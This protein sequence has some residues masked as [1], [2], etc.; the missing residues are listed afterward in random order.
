M[1]EVGGSLEAAILQ[2]N[3]LPHLSQLPHVQSPCGHHH[4]CSLLPTMSGLGT[5]QGWRDAPI[6]FLYLSGWL[7]WPCLSQVGHL[8]FSRP[9]SEWAW[10][11]PAGL[12]ATPAFPC[13]GYFP[14]IH[15]LSKLSSSWVPLR[16]FFHWNFSPKP[17]TWHD[18]DLITQGMLSKVSGE[19]MAWPTAMDEPQE[20]AYQF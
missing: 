10:P 8:R 17:G 2:T 12:M 20:A 4:I 19:W 7:S 11:Q 3:L 5:F 15:N 6:G 1:C 13:T 18:Q 9:G 16:T 14:G